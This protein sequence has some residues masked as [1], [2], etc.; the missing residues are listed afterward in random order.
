M[1]TAPAADDPPAALGGAGSVLLGEIREQPAAL[2]RLLEHERP[3]IA[4]ERAGKPGPLPF[5]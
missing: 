2:L 3:N 1:S 5:R 4:A